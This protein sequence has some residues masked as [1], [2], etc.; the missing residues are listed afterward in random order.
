MSKERALEHLAKWGKI[1]SDVIDTGEST[2]TVALAAQQI[3]VQPERIAK[4]L[5][6]YAKESGALLVLV[7]G[8]ARLDNQKFKAQF[9]F[10]PRMLSAADTLELTGHQPGG[11]CPFGLPS[12]AQVYLD[13][14]LE[15]FESVFPACGSSSSS[16]ELTLPELEEYSLSVGWVDVCKAPDM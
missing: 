13:R 12:G 4:S 8:T 3:G 11:V 16:I 9:G 7:S 5:A 1:E 15:G 14:S 10:K 6:V 2:A